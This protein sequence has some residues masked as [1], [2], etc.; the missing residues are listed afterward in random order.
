GL[1]TFWQRF[2]YIYA[3]TALI[4]YT[5]WL[6]D[7]QGTILIWVMLIPLLSYFLLGKRFGLLTT[8]IALTIN[9]LVFL[10]QASLPKTHIWMNFTLCYFIIWM[11]SHLYESARAATENTMRE[12][13]LKDNL[14]QCRNRLAL[15]YQY[16]SFSRNAA[17]LDMHV[18]LLDIDYFKQV[19]DTFGHEVGDIVLSQVASNISKLI[20]NDYL[21]RIGGEEF[22]I[23][24][25]N[26]T[27]EN[28][29][30]LAEIIRKNIAD[31]TIKYENKMIAITAS[32]GLSKTLN[33]DTTLSDLLRYAD[34]AL[35]EAKRSGRNNIKYY[36]QQNA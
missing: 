34:I 8:F 7:V 29:V 22:C 33:D 19:N 9:I 6:S 31:N 21:Y 11:I 25:N 35:Y 5:V 17:T 2:F 15:S 36:S 30:V 3:L 24:L 14:T 12:L 20:D 16:E 4:C 1:L 23:L 13:A 32:I 10:S 28:A 18:L 26:V 27:K